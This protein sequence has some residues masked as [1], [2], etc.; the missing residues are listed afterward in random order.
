MGGSDGGG[1]PDGSPPAARRAA[2]ASACS[3]APAAAGGGGKGGDSTRPEC[4]QTR[5][6]EPV[7]RPMA[8]SAGAVERIQRDRLM[9]ERGRGGSREGS[10]QRPP[11]FPFPNS[12]VF[13]FCLPSAAHSPPAMASATQ[14][15]ALA[16][17]ASPLEKKGEERACERWSQSVG[18]RQAFHFLSTPPQLTTGPWLPGRQRRQCPWLR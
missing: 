7:D 9:S 15:A 6:M 10:P 16:A 11:F 12:L 17:E 5:S 8:R 1:L 2:A 3:P 13:F 18:R 4:A 14:S